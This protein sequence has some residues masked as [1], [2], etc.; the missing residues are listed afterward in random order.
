V[1]LGPDGKPNTG[2]EVPPSQ[3]FMVLTRAQN[4]PGPDGVLGDD[5]ATPRD[6]SADDI[7]DANNTDSPWVDQSQ[8]YTSHSSHQAFLREYVAGPAGRD[9]IA[10]NADDNGPVDAGKLLGG[11][12]GNAPAAWP[13]GPP[14]RRR[15]RTS[16]GSSSSTRTC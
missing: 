9:G 8:T 13:R 15:P 16:S 10:A 1:T 11:L 6:E 7:Q 14:S 3:R 5:P 12:P 2:D 4:Q